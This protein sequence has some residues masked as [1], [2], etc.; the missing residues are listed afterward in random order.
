MVQRRFV[1]FLTAFLIIGVFM[2]PVD[3][4]HAQRI[5]RSAD[6]V[7]EAFRDSWNLPH[8]GAFFNGNRNG[9]CQWFSGPNPPSNYNTY[10]WWGNNLHVLL[11]EKSWYLAPWNHS[12]AK[13]PSFHNAFLLP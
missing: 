8:Y 13:N 3:A 7:G 6:H 1:A 2:L 10:H 4:A 11:V 5:G 12:N 9:C